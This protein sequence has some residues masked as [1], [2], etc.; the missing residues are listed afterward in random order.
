MTPRSRPSIALLALA[1]LAV[2]GLASCGGGGGAPAAGAAGVISVSDATID[3]P[4][5]PEIAAVRMVVHNR[6]GEADALIA[7]A[8]PIGRA[9]V[10][11]TDVDDAGTASMTRTDRLEVAARSTVTFEPSGLHVMVT[12]IETELEI[13][14]DVPLT[15]TFEE[16]GEIDATATVVEPGSVDATMEADHDH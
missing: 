2:A 13:G 15:L 7:I 4:A 6:T 14:D 9:E 12:Q 10:H 3:W 1:V 16:A 8:T 5:N 11:R